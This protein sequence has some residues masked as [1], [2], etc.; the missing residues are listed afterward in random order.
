M[1]RDRL[2]CRLGAIYPALAL[3]TAL[4]LNACR[5]QP[6]SAPEAQFAVPAAL[7]ADWPKVDGI[8]R[9]YK[10]EIRELVA[11]RTLVWNR[12]DNRITLKGSGVAYSE[13]FYPGGVA[14]T[15]GTWTVDDRNRLC[16]DFPRAL[17]SCRGVLAAPNGYFVFGGTFDGKAVWWPMT[18][19]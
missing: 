2:L 17:S 8:R 12:L 16:L 15:S 9:V 11:D 4:C 5:A 18:I 7:P 1:S 19:H 3:A 10:A 13:L 6:A 14:Q